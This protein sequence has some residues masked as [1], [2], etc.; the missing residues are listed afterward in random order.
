M[1]PLTVY[2]VSVIFFIVFIVL[3]GRISLKIVAMKFGG[4]MGS[5]IVHAIVLN[6]E[7]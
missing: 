7:E 1:R 2:E 6:I 4:V 5:L 3:K